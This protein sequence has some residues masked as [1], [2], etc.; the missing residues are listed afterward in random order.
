M[1]LDLLCLSHPG[2]AYKNNSS[3]SF[4]N[5]PTNN[6]GLPLYPGMVEC[7]GNTKEG[8]L[9]GQYRID[10]LVAEAGQSRV[11]VATRRNVENPL[12]ISR[13][14]V[15]VKAIRMDNSSFASDPAELRKALDLFKTEAELLTGLDHPNIVR[16]VGHQCYD[17]HRAY[18]VMDFVEGKTLER[19]MQELG[20]QGKRIGCSDLVGYAVQICDVLEYIHSQKDGSGRVLVYRDLSPDNV[21]VQQ[22]GAVKL[23]DFG[24]AQFSSSQTK[25][26]AR[27]KE[28]YAPPEQYRGEAEPRSDQYGLA[29][30]LHTLITG[31]PATVPF[32]FDPISQVRSDAPPNL[33][34]VLQRALSFDANLR[35]DNISDFKKALTGNPSIHVTGAV[36]KYQQTSKGVVFPTDVKI[37]YNNVSGYFDALVHLRN[38]CKNDSLSLQPKSSSGI[39]RPLN[40]WE[41]WKLV[42]DV[43]GAT[44]NHDLL[45]NYYDSCTGVITEARTCNFKVDPEC[46]A[47]INISKGHGDY[48]P[49]SDFKG[50]KLRQIDSSETDSS[51][52]PLFNEGL[53][54]SGFMNN[55]GWYCALQEDTVLMHDVF[56]VVSEIKKRSNNILGFCVN[57]KNAQN[58]LRGLYALNLYSDCSADSRGNLFGDTRFLRVARKFP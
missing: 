22:S 10:A 37:N 21:M 29:A 3:G 36:P 47:L 12:D 4:T 52:N 25:H 39:V 44:K 46:D 38:E 2:V 41:F 40:F 54:K 18:T 50:I 57:Q 5:C 15:A 8:W 35:Y 24:I 34:V 6:C 20:V 45:N 13:S 31:A 26:T 9:N 48:I 28:S 11:Y 32:Q 53:N 1:S 56:E 49:I 7:Y 30:T 27:G 58:E 14:K 55:K 42:V 33:D 23:L 51:G 19:L 16:L 43:Y 17:I